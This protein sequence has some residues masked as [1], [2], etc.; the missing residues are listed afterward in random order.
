M[1]L[2]GSHYFFQNYIKLP[3]SNSVNSECMAPKKSVFSK[4]CIIKIVSL[5]LPI[6][7]YY[8]LK[9]NSDPVFMYL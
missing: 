2:I 1:T 7:N 9:E 5:F 8:K 3:I 6:I 4:T